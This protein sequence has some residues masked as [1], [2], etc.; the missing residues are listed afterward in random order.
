MAAGQC[1]HVQV[2]MMALLLALA[3]GPQ[4]TSASRSGEYTALGTFNAALVPLYP[5]IE[6]RTAMLIEL[7]RTELL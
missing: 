6:N 3:L 5:Q 1:V 7:V 2:V 4:Q